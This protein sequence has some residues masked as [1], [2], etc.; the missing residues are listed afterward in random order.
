MGSTVQVAGVLLGGIH[1]YD[2]QDLGAETWIAEKA[3][4]EGCTGRR[5]AAVDIAL[6]TRSA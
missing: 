5:Q 4:N 3:G 2:L 1:S 6:M